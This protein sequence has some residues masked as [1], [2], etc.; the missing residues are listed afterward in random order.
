MYAT[1]GSVAAN[2]TL[3]APAGPT[4]PPANSAPVATAP[5]AA[6]AAPSASVPALASAA[7]SAPKPAS[8]VPGGGI[9]FSASPHNGQTLDQQARD[10]YDCYRFGVAQT[11]FDPMTSTPA[12]GK[13]SQADF[14]RARAACFEGRGY[15]V[16]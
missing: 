9:K 11:G 1:A 4:A 6:S 8:S 7:A 2:A 12:A 3:P 16:R 14:D 15:T 5:S 10:Q 13:P